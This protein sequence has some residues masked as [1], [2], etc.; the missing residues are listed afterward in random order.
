[1]DSSYL[2]LC[3]LSSVR[4]LSSVGVPP[5]PCAGWKLSPGRNVPSLGRGCVAQFF[6]AYSSMSE[7]QYFVSFVQFCVVQG[8][9][10]DPVPVIP[11]WLEA[12]IPNTF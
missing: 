8:G 6:T 9:W 12:E 2:D 11:L 10:I 5:S 4:S 1:M 3:L 7:N